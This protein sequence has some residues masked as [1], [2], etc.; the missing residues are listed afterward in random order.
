M[1]TDEQIIAQAKAK[2]DSGSQSLAR[3]LEF[4]NRILEEVRRKK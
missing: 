1:K 2:Q 3:I 4:T